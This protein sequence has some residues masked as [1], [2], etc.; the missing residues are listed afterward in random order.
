[1]ENELKMKCLN[2]LCDFICK[3]SK[4]STRPLNQCHINHNNETL[5]LIS[6]RSKTKSLKNYQDYG[7]QDADKT[8]TLS[9][10]MS[11][12]S[13]IRNTNNNHHNVQFR[14]RMERRA[15]YPHEQQYQSTYSPDQHNE[16]NSRV[17][18]RVPGESGMIRP[19]N[20]YRDKNN[21]VLSASAPSPNVVNDHEIEEEEVTEDDDMNDNY[22]HHFPYIESYRE[23]YTKPELSYVAP[24]N[25]F[26]SYS[27]EDLE[28]VADLDDEH[29]KYFVKT[30]PRSVTTSGSNIYSN[31]YYEPPSFS[32]K[33]VSIPV[34]TNKDQLVFASA[35]P[36]ANIHS[37]RSS[38]H[39]DGHEDDEVS[40]NDYN[41]D[42]HELPHQDTTVTTTN[43]PTVTTQKLTEANKI[44]NNASKSSS[45]SSETLDVSTSQS[46]V[47]KFTLNLVSA[48]I[49]TDSKTGASLQTKEKTIGIIST[50]DATSIPGTPGVDYPIMHDIPQTGFDCDNQRYKGFFADVDAKCQARQLY[51]LN[52]RLYRYIKPPKPSFPEDFTGEHVDNWLIQQWQMGLLPKVRKKSKAKLVTLSQRQPSLTKQTQ[53]QSSK[54]N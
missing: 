44:K 14:N 24:T 12:E 51:V 34:Q 46:I 26:L 39:L 22:H 18:L 43:S 7:Q 36:H 16:Y 29:S 21:E 37:D 38:Q 1:M 19:D 35:K 27:E 5:M 8:S 4:S 45:S 33:S 6:P 48:Q 47:P 40:H 20:S 53:S 49:N 42:D 23:K 52:E 50:T 41:H 13:T 54:H 10:S 32:T 28:N 3:K 9:Q 11:V 25:K 2:S 17:Y 30:R 15:T 31:F